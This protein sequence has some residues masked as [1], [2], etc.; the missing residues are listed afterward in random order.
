MHT[1]EETEDHC[2]N[3]WTVKPNDTPAKYVERTEE[4]VNYDNQAQSTLCDRL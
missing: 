3:D 2:Q 4:T 1:Q